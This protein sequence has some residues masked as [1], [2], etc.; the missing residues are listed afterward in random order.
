MPRAGPVLG[1]SGL[2]GAGGAGLQRPPRLPQDHVRV[3]GPGKRDLSPTVNPN[4]I[5]TYQIVNQN[6]LRHRAAI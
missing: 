5:V 2:G 3:C 6:T 1:G 4:H